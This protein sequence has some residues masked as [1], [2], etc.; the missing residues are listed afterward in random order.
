[1]PKKPKAKEKEIEHPTSI[2]L[3]DEVRTMLQAEAKTQQRSVSWIINTIFEQW[4]AWKK[5][6]N[7]FDMKRAAKE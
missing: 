2:R 5:R 1:M 3:R 6:Q 7:K 4:F